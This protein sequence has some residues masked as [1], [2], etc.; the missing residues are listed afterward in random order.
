MIKLVVSDMDGTLLAWD[1]NLSGRAAVMKQKL[2]E[3]GILFT[4]ATGRSQSLSEGFEQAL[5]LEIPYIACNGAVILRQGRVLERYTI[6]LLGLRPLAKEADNLGMSV[7]FSMG[8]SEFYYRET[9]WILES[10]SQGLYQNRMELSNH[11]WA[12]TR[13]EKVMIMDGHRT[14]RIALMEE[15]CRQLPP[16]Y[17]FTRYTDM[18]VEIVN[19]RA[20]KARGVRFLSR[21]LGIPMDEILAVGDHQNDCEMLQAAGV[22]AAV[23]NAIPAAKK[24]ADYIAEKDHLEGV[25]EAIQ[26]FCRIDMP[27]LSSGRRQ[28][29]D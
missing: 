15:M 2:K 12:E 11:I 29:N 22:G 6:P 27:R 26:H 28:I 16:E 19:H 20:T 8:G 14:G 9:P 21:Y 13:L 4:M 5:S 17:G 3:K 25:I 1:S 23:S 18:A 7:V 24:C 10:K